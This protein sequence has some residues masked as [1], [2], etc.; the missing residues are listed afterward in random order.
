MKKEFIFVGMLILVA[1]VFVGIGI[2]SITGDAVDADFEHDH[3]SHS[4]H[5]DF[6]KES[7]EDEEAVIENVGH[8]HSKH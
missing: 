4:G 6:V 1:L 5:V 7:F 8:D 3:S 2:I